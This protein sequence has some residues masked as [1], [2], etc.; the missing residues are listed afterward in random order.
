LKQARSWSSFLAA[1]RSEIVSMKR[2][3]LALA[4]ALVT[5]SCAGASAEG[6]LAVG[7]PGNVA[8]NG[9]AIGVSVGFPTASAAGQDALVQCKSSEVKS[10][11]RQL[12]RVVRTFKHQCVAIAMDPAPGTP[13]FGWGMA[14]SRWEARSTSLAACSRTAGAS[15]Q[16]ACKVVGTDCD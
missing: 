2:I 7:Q 16:G 9:V 10:S 6:A 13:G 4:A 1:L 15:R 3:Q 11:T 14:A 8:K 5:L 12:C